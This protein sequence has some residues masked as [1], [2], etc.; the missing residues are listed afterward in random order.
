MAA[1]TKAQSDAEALEARVK[2][3]E[4]IVA[5]LEAANEVFGAKVL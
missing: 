3:L 1:K 2:A 4:E 5:R